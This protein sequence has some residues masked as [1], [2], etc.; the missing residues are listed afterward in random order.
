MTLATTPFSCPQGAIDAATTPE[1]ACD[2]LVAFWVTQGVPFTSGHVVS[3]IRCARQDLVFAQARIGGHLRNAFAA[4]TLPSYD[5]GF[6]G[7]TPVVQVGR[8][9]TGIGR[10]PVGTEVYVYGA[11]QNECDSFEFEIAVAEA[12]KVSDGLGG[13]ISAA[14]A[15]LGAT[16]MTPAGTTGASPIPPVTPSGKVAVATGKLVA[17]IPLAAIHA[18]GRLCIP[19]LA[20]EALAFESGTPITGGEPL[21][22]SC[23]NDKLTIAFQ[24]PGVVVHPTTDRLRV[25]LS[26]EGA[27]A[28]TGTPFPVGKTFDILV[29]S[30]GLTIA[31]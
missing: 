22:A 3:A 8:K 1:E 19:R 12:P 20:F 16:P 24:G 9:T 13:Q 18:D 5:D 23:V 30:T 29:S 7:E 17:G 27:L 15:L 10:T 31:F 4:R 11:S 28:V 2:N 14:A 25:H 6:G 21:F 26:L